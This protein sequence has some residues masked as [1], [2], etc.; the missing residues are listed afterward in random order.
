MRRRILVALAVALLLGLGASAGLADSDARPF[1]GR[2]SRSIMWNTG[3]TSGDPGGPLNWPQT[4]W[5]VE[6]TIIA[7]HLGEGLYTSVGW[8]DHPNGWWC[9]GQPPRY[10]VELLPGGTVTFVAANGDELHG[11][12]GNGDAW[13]N[14]DTGSGGGRFSGVWTGGTGRFEGAQGTFEKVFAMESIDSVT[15]IDSLWEGVVGY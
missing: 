14:V 13:L 15:Y 2:V 8:M 9:N 3:V 11:S 7:T 6:G 4:E 1:R 12:L 5:R 10:C